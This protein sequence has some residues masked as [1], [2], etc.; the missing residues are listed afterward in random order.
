M[1]PDFVVYSKDESPQLIIE[2]K[3]KI[4]PSLEWAAK[5][6]RNLIAHGMIQPSPF[7][8][9]VSPCYLYLWKNVTALEAVPPDYEIEASEILAKYIKHSTLK[10]DVISEY[11]LGMIVTSLLND[12]M[13]P[14]SSEK[15]KDISLEWFSK[16]GLHEAIKHG[17]VVTEVVLQ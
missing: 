6:R 9:L 17:S 16:P 13:H 8:L 5:T 2:V 12:L 1:R 11:S 10:L 4:K 7:F 15:I 14:A 3:K